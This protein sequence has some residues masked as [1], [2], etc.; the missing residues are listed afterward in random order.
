ML[1]GRV[2]VAS[3]WCRLLRRGRALAV[4]Q[5][6]KGK[7]KFIIGRGDNMMDFTYVG[8][9]AQAHLQV[10]ARQGVPGAPG[11]PSAHF[12]LHHM[13]PPTSPCTICGPPTSPR[14]MCGPPRATLGPRGVLL[15]L[16]SQHAGV[17]FSRDTP[18]CICPSF[19][20]L[21]VPLPSPP[22][23]VFWHSLNTKLPPVWPQPP[24][25]CCSTPRV[26]SG[27]SPSVP[28]V[29]P[30]A[31]YAHASFHG[32]AHRPCPFALLPCMLK[33]Q[34]GECAF[35][36]KGDPHWTALHEQCTS[37]VQVRALILYGAQIYSRLH[38]RAWSRPIEHS[39]RQGYALVT[40]FLA[41]VA[42]MMVMVMVVVT[43]ACMCTCVANAHL[44]V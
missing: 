7:T 37:C 42:V 27:V 35:T 13:R 28:F 43:A 44:F 6:K 40:A 19:V 36:R 1:L 9:V 39:S 14:T 38:V 34:S 25:P 26:S 30:Q 10:S 2:L 22:I 8:N 12:C 16:D 32:K 29:L 3:Q 23:A 21:R 24:P 17:L 5:A 18:R 31:A 20:C 11:L 15:R 41:G 4:L 33:R